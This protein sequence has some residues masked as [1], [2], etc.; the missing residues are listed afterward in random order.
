MG[1]F[2]LGIPIWLGYWIQGVNHQ[3]MHVMSL[4]LFC[5]GVTLCNAFERANH[6]LSHLINWTPDASR[7]GCTG[8]C[9]EGEVSNWSS[10]PMAQR[11]SGCALCACW[12]RK[13]TELQSHRA[14]ERM[15]IR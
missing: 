2:S 6:S 12:W 15:K 14:I 5:Y 7:L 8:T 4:G 9:T 1:D 10:G 11:H 13:A 3:C